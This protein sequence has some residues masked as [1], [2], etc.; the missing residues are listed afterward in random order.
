MTPAS[1]TSRDKRAV[2][3]TVDRYATGLR[4]RISALRQA[5]RPRAIVFGYVGKTPYFAGVKELCNWV[6]EEAS[7][8]KGV[9]R[10]RYKIRLVKVSGK[11]AS[12]QLSEIDCFDVDFETSLQ[13]MKSKGKWLIGSKLFSGKPRPKSR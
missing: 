6:R 5:F 3:R 13:L 10:F 11:T 8:A 2:L 9:D 7:K 12:V 1:A 4:G